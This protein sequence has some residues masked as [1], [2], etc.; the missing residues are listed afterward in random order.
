M[1]FTRSN[2]FMA[3]AL[4]SSL[5][6]TACSNSNNDEQKQSTLTAST[7]ATG[8]ASNLSE[9][10]AQQRLIK[11]LQQHFKKANKVTL[12]RRTSPAAS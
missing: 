4:A 10:N 9:R 12:I 5:A 1:L 3:C 7:P 11:T 8:E 2:I 6:V